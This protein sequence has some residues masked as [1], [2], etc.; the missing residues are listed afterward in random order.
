MVGLARTLARYPTAVAGQMTGSER[1]ESY[2][3]E[4]KEKG[5]AERP[6]EDGSLEDR[7]AYTSRR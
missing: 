2:V 4:T 3:R 1:E 6:V 5:A 7:T